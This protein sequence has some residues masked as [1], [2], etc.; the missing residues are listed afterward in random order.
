MAYM[1]MKPQSVLYYCLLAFTSTLAIAGP[2]TSE[3]IKERS[4]SLALPEALAIGELNESERE[5]Y[6]LLVGEEAVS[7][8]GKLRPYEHKE[9][10]IGYL[11][12]GA[13]TGTSV[14][15]AA[16]IQP[17]KSLKRIIVRLDHLYI[18]DYPGRGA[19]RIMF[20]FEAKNQLTSTGEEDVTFSQ[21]YDAMEQQ[22]APVIGF[23]IFI[24]L[25]VGPHGVGFQGGTINVENDSDRAALNFMNSG[26]F[27]NGLQLLTTAQPAIA[28]FAGTITGMTELIL[29]RNEN[30]KVQ[31][32]FLGL[33]FDENAAFGARLAEGNYIVVQAPSSAFQ[34][35][36]WTYDAESQRVL[37]KT[38]KTMIPFNYVCFRVTKMQ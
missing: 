18:H 11:G 36:D 17:N 32:F 15:P 27:K 26:P 28:P 3:M 29:K 8:Q 6:A 24:G 19:R 34:W 2:L 7:L 13:S 31:D 16:N 12:F 33:D 35:G 30:R 21:I 20:K 14:T 4:E 10:Q 9:H 22:G 38:A 37:H 23:P 25:N 5:E 1:S